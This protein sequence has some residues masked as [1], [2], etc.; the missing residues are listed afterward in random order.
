[1]KVLYLV[2]TYPKNSH[3]FVRREIRGVEA[4]GIPV[5]RVSIRPP[6]L[7][8][9]EAADREEAARTEVLLK[10][11]AK[12]LLGPALKTLCT[13][14]IAF[15]KGLG[16]TFRLAKGAERSLAVHLAYFAEACALLRICRR[17]GIDH[18]HVHFSTNPPIVAML[19]QAMGG[20][21]FSFTAHGSEEYYRAVS[22][23]LADKV[24]E[25]RFV[26]AISRFG[27]SQLQLFA[28][29]SIHDRIHVVHCGLDEAFLEEATP[30][31]ASG[32]RFL[33]VG[34]MCQQKQPQVLLEAAGLLK[35]RGLD[36]HLDLIG[37]GELD[38][39]VD[40][41]I[42]RHDL[43]D[44]VTRYGTVDGAKVRERIEA[45]RAM[46]LPS[47]AEGLPV[48]LMESMALQRPVVTTYIA[49]IPELVRQ[50]VEGWLVPTGDAEALAGAMEAALQCEETQLHAMGRAAA[51]RARTRH[52]IR[53][54]ARRMVELFRT[55]GRGAAG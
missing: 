43:T 55:Y 30:T 34:R 44:Q 10:D 9:V 32:N 49:A 36:F 41:A 15:L 38:E 53:E 26:A 22:L 27:R 33:F 17:E 50:D 31:P 45:S 19:V 3:T 37:D 28:A 47:S 40:A 7:D 51:E 8:L 48:V 12:S 16:R 25:A 29:P 35:E 4:Q 11:G 20:P 18:I 24:A 14:P 39:V 21:G 46:V 52:D 1:M 42:A 5:H 6:A 54:S 2:N 13:R 23:K